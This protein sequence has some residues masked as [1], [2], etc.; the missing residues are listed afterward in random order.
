V[1]R[2]WHGTETREAAVDRYIN[3]YQLDRHYGGPEEGGWW[4]DSGV[5]V[6]SIPLPE[7][8]TFTQED[9]QAAVDAL[10]EVYTY[11][12]RMGSVLYPNDGGWDYG[13]VLEDEPAAAYPT[14][15]PY[16]E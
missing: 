2:W 11:R 1:V 5:P 7:V 12:N 10:R 4:Y 8:R 16:Y 13:V 9:V 3:I 15:R 6:A 14:E